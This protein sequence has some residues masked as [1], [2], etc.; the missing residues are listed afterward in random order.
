MAPSFSLVQLGEVGGAYGRLPPSLREKE[1]EKVLLKHLRSN[2][3]HAHTPEEVLSV[4]S[5]MELFYSGQPPSPSNT[6][7]ERSFFAAF[8]RESS[9]VEADLFLDLKEKLQKERGLISGLSLLNL[10]SVV[11]CYTKALAVENA[12]KEKEKEEIEEFVQSLRTQIEEMTKKLHPH[13]LISIIG[14][15]ATYGGAALPQQQQRQ[16]QQEQ[17]QQQR[18]Q[19]QEQQMQQRKQK[20][21]ILNEENLHLLVSKNPHCAMLPPLLRQ[22]DVHLILDN[23]SFMQLFQI[24][25]LLQ[26]CGIKHRAIIEECIY[27][28]HTGRY[29]PKPEEQQQQ[30]QQQLQR[31]QQQQQQEQQGQEQQQQQQQQEEQQQQQQVS[32]VVD[33]EKLSQMNTVEASEFIRALAQRIRSDGLLQQQQQH[34]QEQQEQQQQESAAAKQQSVAEVL[35]PSLLVKIAWCFKQF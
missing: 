15:I 32:L 23:F 35:P 2:L 11:R 18:M 20:E 13:E 6:K 17:Q 26:K 21:E 4:V 27:F 30:L 9:G 14:S 22:V 5:L 24:L 33:T 31:L 28:L 16:Q 7:K 25:H 1:V 34:Q 12:F 19:Q 3:K 10:F 29:S 8:S